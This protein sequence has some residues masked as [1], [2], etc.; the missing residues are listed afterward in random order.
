VLAVA[1]EFGLVPRLLAVFTAVLPKGSLGVD[2]AVAC[3][4]GAFHG[5]S[6]I[7]PRIVRTLR[8]SRDED[9]LIEGIGASER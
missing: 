7:V 1:M 8:P 3:G 4:V 5:S 9:K 6:H 2:G